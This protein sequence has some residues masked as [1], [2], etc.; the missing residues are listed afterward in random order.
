M[1]RYDCEHVFKRLD[2]YLDRELTPQEMKLIEE[3]LEICA[4][5]AE[6]YQFQAEVLNAVRSRLQRI[7]TSSRL[8]AKVSSA[9]KKAQGE[10]SD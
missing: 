10:V 7:P 2:D 5:C 1:D 9:L 4:W 6:T 3:H 8:L